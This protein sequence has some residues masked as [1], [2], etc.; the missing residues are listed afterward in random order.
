MDRSEMRMDR[1]EGHGPVRTEVQAKQGGAPKLT[2]WVLLGSLALAVIV[3]VMLMTDT[4]EVP[5]SEPRSA[6]EGAPNTGAPPA[7][8][9]TNQ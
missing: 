4:Y 3:G 8:T 7:D 6:V 1:N 5:P 2:L 9:R